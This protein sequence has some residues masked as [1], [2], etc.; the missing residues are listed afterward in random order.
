[1]KMRKPG[2]YYAE[3]QLCGALEGEGCLAYLS[4]V[5][6]LVEGKLRWWVDSR[7]PL[8]LE[9]ELL[10]FLPPFLSLVLV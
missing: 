8:K 7:L 2:C 3:N 5:D 4:K 10:F 1:M 6:L 9:A